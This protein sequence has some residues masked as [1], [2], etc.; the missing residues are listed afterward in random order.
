ML[1]APCPLA[2]SWL[3]GAW[4]G[5]LGRAP[6][7]VLPRPHGVSDRPSRL[8]GQ[9]PLVP[10]LS[11]SGPA[12]PR[13]QCRLRLGA[14]GLSGK[15][16]RGPGDRPRVP[17]AALPPRASAAVKGAQAA[18]RAQECAPLITNGA[19]QSCCPA[20]PAVT[21]GPSS[22]RARGLSPHLP[23]PRPRA[24]ARLC[25]HARAHALALMHTLAQTRSR[26]HPRGRGLP[27]ALSAAGH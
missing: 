4:P 20:L 14:R 12:Q 24:R 22:C 5:C 27:P 7:C 17:A 23:A 11:S 16:G 15:G 8:A 25:A 3:C 6:G 1:S 9:A 19:A 2:Q 26:S 21:A 13:G 10:K 18:A